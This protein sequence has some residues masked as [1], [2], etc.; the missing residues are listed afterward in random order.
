M[1]SY[2]E[3]NKQGEDSIGGWIQRGEV[4]PCVNAFIGE[5]MEPWGKR[6]KEKKQG[7]RGVE[8]RIAAA[9]REETRLGRWSELE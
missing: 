1:H 3:K 8:L 6:R 2:G 9:G 4:E 5:V 7:N